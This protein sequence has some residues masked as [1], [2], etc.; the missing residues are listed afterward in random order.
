MGYCHDTRFIDPTVD[1][2]QVVTPTGIATVSPNVYVFGEWNTGELQQL[3]LDNRGNVVSMTRV[4]TAPAGIIGVEMGM[5]NTLYFTTQN[6]MYEYPN[7]TMTP[8]T[9]NGNNNTG[10]PINILFL[11]ATV[12]TAAVVIATI[13][14]LFVNR[15]RKKPRTVAEKILTHIINTQI[16]EAGISVWKREN[17]IGP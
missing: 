15:F 16:S 1:F 17:D 8:S 10:T 2:A 4:Y 14:F 5:N 13:A 6:T 12:A 7:P 3:Q 9:S 11:T